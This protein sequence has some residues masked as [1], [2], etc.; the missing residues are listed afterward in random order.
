MTNAHVSRSRRV[1]F[2]TL[3]V[4]VAALALA[5]VPA[6]A[7]AAPTEPTLTVAELQ[8]K[9]DLNGGNPIDGWFRTVLKGSTIET[10]PVRILSIT[11]HGNGA[12][13]GTP[14][15]L[16]MF[17]ATGTAIDTIG[18]IAAGMSGSPVFVDD[19]GV[20]TLVG[21]V[22]YGDFFTTHNLG[23][24]TPI[25]FM[26]AIEDTYQ[27][28]STK[29][30]LPAPVKTGG[31]TLTSVIV[32]RDLSA[33]KAAP[34]AAGTAVFAPLAVVQV[35]GLPTSSKLYK[36]W[37]KHFA[38]HG[39][40]L[41]S[42]GLAGGYDPSFETTLEGGA[43][44]AALAS[45]GELWYGAA[46]TVTY[47]T[48]S[49]V[50]A[51]GHPL[52]WEGPSGLT[53]TNAWVDGVWSS[54]NEPYKLI[55]P[56]KVR[57]TLTQDRL[58]GIAGRLDGGPEEVPVTSVATMTDEGVH[59]S[60]ESWLPRWAAD[61]SSWN[62]IGIPAAAA[63]TAPYRAL[64]AAAAAGSAHTTATVVV[65][66]GTKTYTITRSD[67]YDD[68]TDIVNTSI[69]SLDE[70]ATRLQLLNS[71][72]LKLA[73]IVS[74]DY[75]TAISRSRHVSTITNVTTPNGIRHGF[76][77][78]RVF[79]NVR[80][81]PGTS[82]VDA[83]LFIPST[84]SLSGMV[85]V[86]GG[87]TG[88]QYSFGGPMGTGD[89]SVA[90]IAS[91]IASRPKNTD[92]LVSYQPSGRSDSG[93]ISIIGPFA[94]GSMETTIATR[95]VVNGEI[96]KTTSQLVLL[97]GSTV[98]VGPGGSLDVLAYVLSSADKGT[99]TVLRRDADQSKDT[100]LT[101]LTLSNRGGAMFLA[102]S[103]PS[104]WRNGTYTFR[105]EGDA[106]NLG[107]QGVVTVRTAAKVSV[108]ASPSHTTSGRTVTLSS[109]V[110]PKQPS[111]SVVFEYAGRSGWTAI[112]T[113]PL[114][115]GTTAATSWRPAR[116]TWRVRARFTGSLV[117]VPTTSANTTTVKID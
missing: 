86:I 97:T 13:N 79:L 56:T 68:S 43:S 50:V 104:I 66:N 113:V 116:G 17:E 87:S 7:S 64:N 67:L 84:V 111:G 26:S 107:S 34:R 9:I 78:V 110:G 4:A 63:A 77:K 14:D 73:R 83:T 91:D 19:G 65:S 38:D 45:R 60:T 10:I 31:K 52:F 37:V 46:G 11:T 3:A 28:T 49:T 101:Q 95:N 44:V 33:A 54:T 94:T 1:L 76:N 23:L 81:V 47:A 72:D 90:G 88:N 74:V 55:A 35:S 70:I 100:T 71:P 96:S 29:L 112:R 30:A 59:A 41:V 108:A 99:V 8:H 16:I 58:A 27:V 42:Y 22:S 51:F 2:A 114:S 105:Y 18:G 93:P 85:S 62:Y 15:R 82:T 115:G 32:T 98:H 102:Y 61:S 89:T 75:R 25:E 20:A 103:Q 69:S 24:A 106:D 36:E 21:A 109:N 117:N 48:S 57:G 92:I 53:L 39:V 40:T 5:L 6:V 12:L 80:G